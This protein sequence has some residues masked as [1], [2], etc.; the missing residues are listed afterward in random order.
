[1]QLGQPTTLEALPTSNLNQVKAQNELHLGQAKG[2]G[3]DN[4]TREIS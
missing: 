4:I 3:N 2:Q 1:M